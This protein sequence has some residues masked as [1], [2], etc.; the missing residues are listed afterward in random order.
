MHDCQIEATLLILTN[1]TF[2]VIDDTP[3]VIRAVRNEKASGK[4][5]EEAKTWDDL[6]VI[7]VTCLSEGTAMVALM[8]GNYITEQSKNA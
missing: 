3:E 6:H 4:I 8:V 7:S 2:L 1:K 5:D